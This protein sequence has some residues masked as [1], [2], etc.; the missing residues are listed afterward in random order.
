M[1]A[2][3][4]W[5]AYRDGDPRRSFQGP[6]PVGEPGGYVELRGLLEQTIRHSE[7]LDFGSARA[8][9]QRACN[10]AA[11][12]EGEPPGPAGS[13]T[14]QVWHA[15]ASPVSGGPD[16]PLAPDRRSPNVNRVA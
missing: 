16:T 6:D 1:K 8:K 5:P 3:D 15:N 14:P 7:G 12:L 4:A 11:S 13:R 9:L 2:R 10:R